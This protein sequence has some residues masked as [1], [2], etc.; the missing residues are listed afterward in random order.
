MDF[1]YLSIASNDTSHAQL[2][3]DNLLAWLGLLFPVKGDKFINKHN[4]KKK[5]STKVGGGGN[6]WCEC[7]RWKGNVVLQILT[8]IINVRIICSEYKNSRVLDPL[9]SNFCSMSFQFPWQAQISRKHLIW[10]LFSHWFSFLLYYRFILNVIFIIIEFRSIVIV[11]VIIICH[12]VNVHFWPPYLSYCWFC[13]SSFDQI[14][15]RS[16]Q[17]DLWSKSILLAKLS[18]FA[19]LLPL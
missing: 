8:V 17:F 9:S 6:C 5:R 15:V 16:I 10:N 12:L 7:N 11:E 3:A 13:C 1:W 14:I 19:P 4:N 18:S 2:C